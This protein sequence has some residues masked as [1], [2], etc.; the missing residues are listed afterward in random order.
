MAS[1]RVVGWLRLSLVVS[2]SCLLLVLGGCS[3]NSVVGNQGKTLR[4]ANQPAFPPFEFKGEDG[5][6]QGFSIDLMNAI[7]RAANFKVDWQSIPFDGM[8]PALQ[9]NTIDA[10]ISSSTLR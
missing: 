8:I 4:V 10:A 3:F 6:S 5:K 1:L 2:L 7:A 9:A